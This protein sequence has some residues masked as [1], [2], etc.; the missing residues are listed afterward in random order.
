M[1]KRRG[2]LMKLDYRA[3]LTTA[4]KRTTNIIVD[5]LFLLLTKKDFNEITV[6]EICRVGLI[7]H[8]TF[9]NYFEDKYDVIRWTFFKEVYKYYPEVD[10]VM[11]H[12]ENI[13]K[14][15]DA[16]CDFI[17]KNKGI[18]SKVAKKNPM[19]G[20][21]HQIISQCCYEFGLM[22]AANCTRD[23]NFDYPYEVVFN[24]YINGV[25]EILNQSFYFGKTYTRK[26]IHNYF[27]DFFAK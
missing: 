2:E 4:Q 21:Y 24:N 17:D 11:N 8:S 3:N 20:A 26:Q 19:N 16:I 12:Y 13:D 9:Y 15:A 1:R 27:K 18:L 6:R 14:C 5:T 22:L 25:I 10:I 7:P 23:K